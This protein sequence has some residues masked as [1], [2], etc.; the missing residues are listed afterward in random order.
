MTGVFKKCLYGKENVWEL[1]FIMRVIEER[2]RGIWEWHA[3][4]GEE[5]PIWVGETVE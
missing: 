2:T 1:C 3:L 4:P 5:A